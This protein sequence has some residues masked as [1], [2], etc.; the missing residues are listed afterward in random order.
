MVSLFGDFLEALTKHHFQ[1]AKRV[2]RYLKGT[3]DYGMM[4]KKGKC[5]KLIGFNDDD[6]VRD[7]EDKKCTSD[8]VFMLS[9][10]AIYWSLKKHQVITLSITENFNLL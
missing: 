3:T 4:Y 6:Y 9:S 5:S 8:Y 1:V 7:L 10:K 2:F